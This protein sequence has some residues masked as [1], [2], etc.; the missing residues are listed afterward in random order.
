M[1]EPS[2]HQP[3]YGDL[4]KRAAVLKSNNIDGVYLV[5]KNQRRDTQPLLA[6]LIELSDVRCIVL[7][8]IM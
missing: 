8:T 6:I 4:A 5:E 3:V 1:S 2:A 7:S